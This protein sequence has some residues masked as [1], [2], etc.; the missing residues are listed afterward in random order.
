MTNRKQWILL[1]IGLL[2][3]HQSI[4]FFYNQPY[5]PFQ[6]LVATLVFSPYSW[7]TA[8]VMFIAGFLCLSKVVKVH[9]PLLHTKL[10][11]L[12]ISCMVMSTVFMYTYSWLGV[13]FLILAL[14][15]GIMD[16][17]D[18]EKKRKQ[19]ILRWFI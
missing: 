7:A 18:L 19:E 17:V 15:Y 9:Y 10:N 4:Q 13:V 5:R 2:L 12:F 11:H 8:I 3:G 14:I 6:I 16:A 1:T